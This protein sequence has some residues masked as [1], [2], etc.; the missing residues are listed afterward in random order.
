[1]EENG[2]SLP[3]DPPLDTLRQLAASMASALHGG[4]PSQHQQPKDVSVLVPL[5][6]SEGG[7]TRRLASE[8][9]L[10]EVMTRRQVAA[11]QR[12]VLAGKATSRNFDARS[13]MAAASAAVANRSSAGASSSSKETSSLLRSLVS[14]SASFATGSNPMT[15][16]APASASASAPAPASAAASQHSEHLKAAAAPGSA[17]ADTASVS[18]TGTSTAPLEEGELERDH[19]EED[20]LSLSLSVSHAQPSSASAAAA[21][22]SEAEP[23]AELHRRKREVPLRLA[24]TAHYGQAVALL[25][26][27]TDSTLENERAAISRYASSDAAARAGLQLYRGPAAAVVTV[28]HSSLRL[29]RHEALPARSGGVV[30]WHTGTA[31]RRVRRYN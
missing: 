15:S 28:D 20:Q 5:F 3:R 14:T 31:A 23:P 12:L 19:S 9:A 1:M 11:T 4:V 27:W 18:E 13:L 6:E 25:R 26:A 10:R 17:K 22:A 7:R 16:A 29:Y 8:R 21:T 24:D 30:L 2:K